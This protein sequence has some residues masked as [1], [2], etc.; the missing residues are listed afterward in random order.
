MEVK[1]GTKTAIRLT[2][3]LLVTLTFTI[4][5]FHLLP[6]LAWTRP[7]INISI[8]A[9]LGLLALM[10]GAIANLRVRKDLQLSKVFFFCAFVYLGVI[11]LIGAILSMIGFITPGSM[12]EPY[13]LVANILEFSIFIGLI[14]ASLFLQ[15]FRNIP[16]TKSDSTKI[17]GLII[18]SS[19]A[20]YAFYYLVV[21]PILPVIVLYAI[22]LYLTIGTLCISIGVLYYT[23][24]SDKLKSHYTQFW[25][26]NG[27]L[28]SVFITPIFLLTLITPLHIWLLAILFLT[29]GM[30]T[31]N[32]AVS[33]PQF[34]STGMTESNSFR[35]AFI[36]NLFVIMPFLAAFILEFFYSSLMVSSELYLLIRVGAGIISIGTAIL[37]FL[38]SKQKFTRSF[39]PL[40]LAFVVW[41]IV[42]IALLTMGPLLSL[43]NESLIPY[44]VGYLIVFILLITAVYWKQNPPAVKESGL[45]ILRI[46]LSIIG[47]V[48]ALTISIIIETWLIIINPGLIASPVDRIILICFSFLN[49]FLF[50][51]L[52]YVYLKESRGEITIEILGL[53]FLMLWII[54]GILKSIFSMWE[55]GWWAAEFL[56][57]GGLMIAPIIFGIAYLRALQTTEETEKRATLYADILAHDISN[58][59]QAILTSMELIELD[60]VPDEIREQAVEQIHLS[61]SRADHLIK[62]V[63]RLGK[64]EYMPDVSFQ[65]LDL[66]MYIHLAFDQVCRALGDGGFIL[67]CDTTEG[68]AFVD[69][70]ILLVDL[71]QNLIRNAMEYSNTKKEIEVKIKLLDNRD[72]PW[73]EVQ[74]ID[75]GRGIPPERKEQLFNR[76]MDGAH[77]SGLGLSVVRALSEAFGGW[78]AVQDRI[79][80]E[81][82]KGT[83]FLVYLPVSASQPPQ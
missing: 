20:G 80:R 46:I 54:P 14:C 28:L 56:L 72:K 64:V 60:E 16:V 67:K 31:F 4:I 52:G 12:M 5:G 26:L 3:N 58:Y 66:V 25:L 39:I 47:I 65:P 19:L 43:F 76:Y 51:I 81:Y 44:I 49:V 82:Q 45:P 22:G 11:N 7:H 77:G 24:R 37:L 6:L 10:G 79:P 21:L 17:S 18:A 33:I 83:V 50:T 32:L 62:N 30:V 9:L 71:F 61:L 74:V 23:A 35:Y 29:F 34:H 73:W 27:L 40:M 42:D 41:V 2:V 78:V 53:S 1:Q 57:L 13:R 70:N 15:V 69:A 8:Y 59:H 38:Y 63:R 48:V 75:F 68:K 55:W 36:L